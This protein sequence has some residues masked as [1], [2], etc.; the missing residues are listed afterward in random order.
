M[1]YLATGNSKRDLAFAFKI[2]RATIYHIII[3]ACEDIWDVLREYVRPPSTTGDW[4][5]FLDF[6][7][8]PHCVGALDGQYISIRKPPSSGSLWYNYKVL[9]AARDARYCFTAVDVGEYVSNNDSGIL[10]NSKM[11][12]RFENDEMSIPESEKILE[13]DLELPYFFVRNEIFPLQT[14]LMR[15]F[16]GKALINEM[17]KIFNYCLSRARRILEKK[18]G[19]LVP[20]WRIFLKPIDVRPENVQKLVLT[21]IALDKY[22]RQTNVSYSP[23]E[24]IDCENGDGEIIRG[25]QYLPKYT[26]NLK[27]KVYQ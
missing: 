3:K 19:I 6:W 16:P 26:K 7:D 4:K 27:L 22:L 14:W 21:V 11:G 9:S 20:S 2:S 13:D 1:C 25:W 15:L 23:T 10:R 18:F 12:R 24:F 8:M 5:E 17:H